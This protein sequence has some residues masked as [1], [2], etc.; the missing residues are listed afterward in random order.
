MQRL[1]EHAR[2]QSRL[3]HNSASVT[4]LSTEFDCF[5]ETVFK[6]SMVDCIVLCEIAVEAP[7]LMKVVRA[8]QGCTFWTSLSLPTSR[9]PLSETSARRVVHFSIIPLLTWYALEIYRT[10][11]FVQCFYCFLLLLFFA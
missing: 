3:P 4:Y 11:N 10:N 1:Q 9:S 7:A 2:G 5:W 6:S 8:L